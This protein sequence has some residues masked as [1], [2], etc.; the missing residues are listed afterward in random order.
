MGLPVMEQNQYVIFTTEDRHYAI[1]VAFVVQIIPAV[2]ITAVHDGPDLLMGVIDMRGEVVPVIDFRRQFKL[3]DKE[4]VIDDKMIIARISNH[5]V[6]FFADAIVEVA[7]L[8]EQS[9]VGSEDIFPGMEDFISGVA[10][11]Q[12]R[13]V[14]IYAIEKLFPADEIENIASFVCAQNESA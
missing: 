8:T 9:T 14:L 12:G 13:T 6:A 5:A 4:V 2:W 3:P 11:H 10:R 7:S 1:P